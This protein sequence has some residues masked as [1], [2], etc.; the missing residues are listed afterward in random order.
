MND[1]A[2]VEGQ[3]SP[4]VP[5]DS[6]GYANVL[7]I[8]Y[9]NRYR[10]GLAADHVLH[11]LLNL[12]DNMI[13]KMALRLRKVRGDSCS[14]EDSYAE[15]MAKIFELVV[16]FDPE[17]LQEES[18]NV[19][20]ICVTVYLKRKLSAWIG[21]ESMRSSRVRSEQVHVLPVE[22]LTYMSDEQQGVAS[23]G[24]SLAEARQEMANYTEKTRDL[25]FLR[26]VLN[27]TQVE[28]AAI[29]GISQQLMALQLRDTQQL[30][31]ARART[32]VESCAST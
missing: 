20:S 9:R 7:A 3:H 21:W 10:L 13:Y 29:M 32:L 1:L 12:L 11:D 23:P 24:L 27:F 18:Q 30:L 8:S 25:L 26:Y 28:L 17:R 4:R 22:T 19:V 5:C 31:R 2:A 6:Y 14:I 16:V 15:I